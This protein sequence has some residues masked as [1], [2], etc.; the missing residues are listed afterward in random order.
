MTP[1]GVRFREQQEVDFVIVGAGASGG[2]LAKELATAGLRVVV[3]EQGPYRR[4][5]DFKHDELANWFLYDLLPSPADHPQTFRKTPADEAQVQAAPP[6]LIYA[7]GVGGS[8]VHFT[9]NFWRFHPIDFRERSALGPIAGTG[10]ADWPITYD[11]LEP[12]Y[13]KV[14]WEI[15]VSGAPGP[16]D[17]PRSR[18][19]PMPPLPV[20]SSGVLLERGATR[21]GWHA[22][23]APMAITSQAHDGRPAC[24]HCGHCMFYGCEMNAK[25]STLATVIPRAE[26]TGRCEIRPG[27]TVFRLETDDAG[28][29][30]RAL[31]R[32]ADGRE[33]AQR[34][35]AFI[36]A[37]N[38]AETARLLLLSASPRF[39]DGLANSSGLVGKHLMFNGQSYA[40]GLFEHPLNE[41]KSVQV[42]RI[43]HDFYDSDPARGFYGG[44]GI[45]ARMS[46]GPMLF[47]LAGLPPDAPTWGAEYKRMLGEYY[48]HTVE[49]NGHTTSLPLEANSITL[50]PTVKDK[51]GDPALR[52]TYRDHADDLATMR[53]L[54]DR[55]VE[56]LE[57]AGAA[58]IWKTPV[59]EATIGAHLLGT[60]R[61]GNDA[62]TSVVDRFHR[63]HDVRNLFL[64][65][66]GSFV[67]SGRGQPTM[68]IQALAFRAGEHI[69]AFARRGE[70]Q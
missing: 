69:A 32:D 67:T 38:G 48:T 53:F 49:V 58:R 18:P 26:A 50:D 43:L 2:V 44:G 39:P 62:R 17:P 13:T 55:S 40:Y 23:P 64:C 37:A 28:R 16:F 10:F 20:K 60:C 6:P 4:A 22:Q 9:A 68:T 25:S 61:M 47:A 51:W 19:Y 56:L 21:L 31:Y 42:T 34:A 45:D 35:R 59:A 66:G 54:Q 46:F 41:Y 29:V 7:Q 63:T 52:V 70:I 33:H 3:L 5:A 65:D 27:S 11:E 30:T 12:Y 36:L 1:H 24:I 15:G 14:D 8:S 57:A